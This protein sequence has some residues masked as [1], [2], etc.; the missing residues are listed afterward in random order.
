MTDTEA[1]IAIHHILDGRAWRIDDL[2]SIAEILTKTGR[3]IRSPLNEID[4]DRMWDEDG[5]CLTCGDLR[6]HCTG[7]DD[8][9]DDDKRSYGPRR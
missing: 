8:T 3:K 4:P 2:E 1:M 6:T 9:V 7:D 5:I